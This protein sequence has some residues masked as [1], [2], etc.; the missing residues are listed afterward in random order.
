MP[1]KPADIQAAAAR[2]RLPIATPIAEKLAVYGDMLL[3]WNSRLALTSIRDEAALIERH[4][5]EGLFAAVHLPAQVAS[6]LDFGS[7]TGIPGIPIALYRTDVRVTL[8][9][10]QRKKA[11]F[12]QEASRLLGLRCVVHAERAETLPAESFGA[13]C[14]RAVDKTDEMLPEAIRL[15]EPHG[16]L[17]LMFGRHSP[18]LG[19]EW[20]WSR[21]ELPGSH[22][23]VLHIGRRS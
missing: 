11:A 10:S 1:I 8:A 12:L 14:M 16:V 20:E 18:E 5:M 6:A 7:G 17:C 3:R 9:E 19:P 2:W 21:F 4:L 15:L 22:G 13:V 23:R